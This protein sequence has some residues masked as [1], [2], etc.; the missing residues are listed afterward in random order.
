MAPITQPLL[1]KPV[2]ELLNSES[3]KDAL[4]SNGHS[5]NFKK[6]LRIK[7]APMH[8]VSENTKHNKGKA[9]NSGFQRRESSRTVWKAIVVLIVYL[10]VGLLY[11]LSIK[12][13]LLGERTSSFIDTLYFCIVTMTTVGYGDLVPSTVSAKL[14]TCAFVF[15]GFGIVGAILSNAA[16]YLV[17]KQEKFLE[18]AVHRKNHQI[19]VLVKGPK[20]K[21]VHWKVLVTGII[22]VSLFGLGMLVLIKLEH[23]STVDAFYVVSVTVTT[24]GYGDQSFKTPPGRAFAIVWILV[25]TLSV[26]QFF[27]CLAEWATEARQHSLADWVLTRKVTSLDLEAADLD[28]DG[29]VS[30]AEFIIFKLKEMGQIKHDDVVTCMKEFNELDVDQSGTL[31]LSDIRLAQ[32]E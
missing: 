26:A 30:A 8:D 23:K 6:F 32:Y 2:S 18:K 20:M 24:L 4:Q 12:D 25:S 16:H 17:E 7:S 3:S 21:P 28:D 13:E 14:L 31:S 11:F 5:K 15:I 27:L 9:P 10:T 19:E 29:V 22:V 1:D